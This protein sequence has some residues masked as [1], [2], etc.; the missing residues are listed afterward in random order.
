MNQIQVELV[1]HTPGSP[2]SGIG[3]YTRELQRHLSEFVTTTLT[4]QVDPPLSEYLTTLRHFPI[5]VTDHRP[6]SIVHFVEDLGCSQMLWRPLRPAVAT[7]HDLGVIAW[8]P[9]RQMHPAIDRIVW[10]LSYVGLKK[11]DAVIAV[12]NFSRQML[13]RRLRLDPGRVFTVHSGINTSTFKPIPSARQELIAR[14]RLP[15]AE[16]L[17]YLTYVGTEIP[18]KN[19][20]T[21]LKTLSRLPSNVMLLKVGSPG[22]WRARQATYDAIRHLGLG[23]RVLFYED[24]PEDDLPLFYCTADVYIACSFLEG[25]GHPILEAM[26][27]GTPVICSNV[28]SLPEVAG[29][30][31]ILI[32]PTDDRRFAEAVTSVLSDTRLRKRMVSNGLERTRKFSWQK[33]A[34]GVVAVYER[35]ALDHRELVVSGQSG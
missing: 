7:S 35:V 4:T 30:A 15:A 21:I 19:M 9:E 33:T 13:I 25:F 12:S 28:A 2:H 20:L 8:P 1:E 3:R 26:A 34:E 18:R 22:T 27:C 23:G 17:S 31:A 24:V 32:H 14:Y 16:E 11:M 10:R 5:G 6:G 29:D